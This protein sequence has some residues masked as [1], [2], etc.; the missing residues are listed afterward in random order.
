MEG[1]E[2]AYDRAAGDGLR[3][4]VKESGRCAC[5][6]PKAGQTSRSDGADRRL[7][8]TNCRKGVV[9][10][11][12]PTYRVSLFHLTFHP[13][14]ADD[15]CGSSRREWAAKTIAESC[16]RAPKAE[17][18]QIQSAS[19]RPSPL[20]VGDG[21]DSHLRRSI[22]FPDRLFLPSENQRLQRNRSSMSPSP[23]P[24]HF[25]FVDLLFF[26]CL[27]DFGITCSS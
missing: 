18:N 16:F 26:I 15:M 3:T 13:I 4:R 11:V 19:S 12:P 27:P 9:K 24:L 10:N 1:R 7:L 17:Y 20:A 14:V 25:L 22:R 23:L 8:W 6:W 2:R 5:P 21:L